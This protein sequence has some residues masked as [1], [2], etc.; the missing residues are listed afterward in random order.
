VGC[1]LVDR[2]HA[3]A[4]DDTDLRAEESTRQETGEKVVDLIEIPESTVSY[5]GM[6]RGAGCEMR[7]VCTEGYDK[8]GN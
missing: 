7:C 2:E 1:F 3:K 8:E 5:E 4:L 6:V